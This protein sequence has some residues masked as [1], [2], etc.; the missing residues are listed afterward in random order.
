MT[1]T[2]LEVFVTLAQAGSFSRAAMLLGIT[3]SAVSHSMRG[4]ERELG[5]SLLFR[6]RANTELTPVGT[7]LL[8]QAYEIRA[9]HDALMQGAKD[10]QGLHSGVLRIGS[11]GS[12]SSL[13]ILPELLTR[14]RAMHPGVEVYVDEEND[15]TVARW[16][17]ERRVELGFVVLPD[18]RFE[19]VPLVEDEL[20]VVMAQGHPLARESAIAPAQLNDADF[21]LTEAGCGALIMNLFSHGDIRPR[22]RYRFTQLLSIL[23]FVEQSLAVSV[24]ARLALPDAY[25]GVVYRPFRP[26]AP[27]AV[28]LAMR[29]AAKLSPAA[30]AFVEL[31]RETYKHK[32]KRQ[33][34]VSRL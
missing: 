17:V 21:V 3:Q 5:V 20:M 31:A 24:A 11:F 28:G 15:E 34:A 33:Q 22:I 27:R 26:R 23:G 9:A 30:R 10:A 18:E 4:L 16:L 25:P 14:Y 13:R 29:D 7:Q 1:F 32:R 19:T 8:A 12:S 2:Q 6:D